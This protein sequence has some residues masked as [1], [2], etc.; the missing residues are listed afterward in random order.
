M[1]EQLTEIKN[2]G[3]SA[4]ASD[5]TGHG[6]DHIQRVAAI[7]EEILKT[8]P[9]ADSFIALSAAYLHDTIDDK[10]TADP[11]AAADQLATFLTELDVPQEKIQ[12]IFAIIDNMSYSKELSGKMELSL[13]GKI[14]QDADRIDALGAIGILRTSYFGGG[15]G[16]PIHDPNML[17]KTFKDKEDYRKG[18]TVI[19]H[20]YEKLFL[21]S[22]TMNTEYGKKEAK[23]RE[24]FM[25][26]FLDEFYREWGE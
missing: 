10:V 26:E 5:Q 8:E 20:F 25:K 22:E 14:V 16:H 12:A 6:A 15:H 4:L 1:K 17:P 7:A 11:Q 18:T 23:R 19:N 2:Y 21:L 13:E 9:K 24:A 3:L